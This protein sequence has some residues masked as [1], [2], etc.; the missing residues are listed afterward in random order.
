M[1]YNP[2]LLELQRCQYVSTSLKGK[3]RVSYEG[4][5]QPLILE[6]SLASCCKNTAIISLVPRAP[7]KRAWYILTVHACSEF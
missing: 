6:H 1:D 2:P 3:K 7:W 5:G 4:G